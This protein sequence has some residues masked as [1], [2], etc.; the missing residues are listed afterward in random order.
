MESTSDFPHWKDEAVLLNKINPWTIEVKQLFCY[1]SLGNWTLLLWEWKMPINDCHSLQADV[2]VQFMSGQGNSK[3][4]Q[5]DLSHEGGHFPHKARK[6]EV[7]SGGLE[8]P[9][10]RRRPVWL[11]W[12]C[13]SCSVTLGFQSL[14]CKMAAVPPHKMPTFQTPRKDH[15]AFF[16]QSFVF[17][18]GNACHS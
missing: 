2:R 6:R 7:S 12:V 15:K 5:Y 3:L 10:Y 4:Y 16:P 18:C 14:N 8:W 13:S 17:S 1:Q 9:L 11:R